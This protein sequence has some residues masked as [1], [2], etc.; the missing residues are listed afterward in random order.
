MGYMSIQHLHTFYAMSKNYLLN[1]NTKL[2]NIVGHVSSNYR[3]VVG[4][5][6]VYY[7]QTAVILSIQFHGDVV[8]LSYRYI[9]GI[10][11]Y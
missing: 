9:A 6:L 4:T 1:V 5:L 3:L 8:E 7:R 11:L 10:T 2:S